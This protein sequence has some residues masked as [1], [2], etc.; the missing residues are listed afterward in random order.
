MAKKVGSEADPKVGGSGKGAP[1]DPAVHNQVVTQESYLAAVKD[2]AAATAAVKAANET[3]K[4]VRKKWKASGIELGVLDATVR[5]AEWSR[6]EIRDHFEIQANYAAW[7]GLP[8]AP[9]VLKQGEFRGLD[10]AEIQRREWFALGRT[11]SRTGKPGRPPE[12]CPP[13]YHQAFMAGYN[14]EDEAAWL[15]ADKPD[16]PPP[17]ADPVDASREKGADDAGVKVV[18]DDHG[19]PSWKGFSDDPDDWFAAQRRD[20]LVWFNGLPGDA[21]VRISH[22]GVLTAFR[23]VRDGRRSPENLDPIESDGLVHLFDAY[24]EKLEDWSNDQAGEFLG[25]VIQN[26]DADPLPTLAHKAADADFKRQ[27]ANLGKVAGAGKGK[28]KS[29]PSVH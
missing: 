15:D 21:N 19:Q 23:D 14:E 24:P 27:M 16:A 7:L 1:A 4:A 12:E 10:D 3:R 11:A 18:G 2:I 13:E 20:F 29:S 25:W 22:K 17:V 6:G 8:V 26:A 28:G 9:G 5:L